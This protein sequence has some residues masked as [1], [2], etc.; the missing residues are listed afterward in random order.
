MA[1]LTPF[2][3]GLFSG[4]H[5][6]AMCGGLCAVICPNNQLKTLL[7]VN[8]GRIISYTLLGALAAGLAQGL[9]MTIDG[10]WIS[11]IL[12]IAMG[13]LLILAGLTIWLDSK[14]L[15]IQ[16][17]WPWWH[18][19]Q[20]YLRRLNQSPQIGLHW[21]KGMLW[22]LIPCGLLYGMLLV[23]MTTGSALGGAQYMFFFGLGTVFPLIFSQPFI[24]RWQSK[25]RSIAAIFVIIV[26]IWSM[27]SPFFVHGL[28][29]VESPWLIQLTLVLDRCIPL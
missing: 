29:P 3:I 19:V 7:I 13:L 1:V 8:L 27:L 6:I 9:L 16:K 22:G 10:A 18:K 15:N 24:N 4:L 28:I 11:W 23:S 25:G 5:C 14:I 21:I 20:Q 17:V 2:L 26:G 12:R